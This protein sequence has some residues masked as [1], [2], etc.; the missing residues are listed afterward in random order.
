M[1]PERDG[2]EPVC[3]LR[4]TR[5]TSAADLVE[6]MRLGGGFSAVK[7]ADAADTLAGMR[8]SGM[9]VLFSFPA[10]VVATG[11]RGVIRDI[12]K[13]RAVDALI[14]TCGTLDHDLARLWKEYY[15]GSF[16]MDDAELLERGIHR[17]GSVL[18]PEGSYGLLL[19]GKLQPLLGELYREK[20]VWGPREMI[21]AVAARLDH[22]PRAEESVLVQ[23]HRNGI[24][25]FVPGI[26]DGAFGSQA[27]QFREK[28]RDFVLDVLQDE[29]ELSGLVF[30]SRGLGALIVG[31][32]ISKH[33]AIWWAQFREGLDA[34]VSITTAPEYDGSLSGARLRE[35]ISWGKLKPAAKQ[36]TLEGDATVLLPL[37]WA[38]VLAKA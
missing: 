26:T 29:R 10:A 2:L 36:V 16:E 21:D 22:E 1:P 5:G 11:V 8:A 25:V 37:L 33:H 27:W 38:A 32:G 3:D 14:T 6:A 28:H 23:A 31:G 20:K 9:T 30:R 19:E 7:I 4:L 13:A 17:L 35:A 24:P 15:R 18:V 12:V 34:A